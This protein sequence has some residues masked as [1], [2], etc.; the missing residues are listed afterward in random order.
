MPSVVSLCRT[1]VALTP[2]ALT[3]RE[4]AADPEVKALVELNIIGKNNCNV[5][6]DSP[7][8]FGSPRLTLERSGYED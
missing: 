8:P 2:A 7:S 5:N 4:L 6:P 3:G 1:I